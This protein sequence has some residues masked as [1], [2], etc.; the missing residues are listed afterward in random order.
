MNGWNL[1]TFPM[2]HVK[3][4]WKNTNKNNNT[5]TKGEKVETDK[6]KRRRKRRKKK[7]EK[8]IAW[9]VPRVH[10]FFNWVTTNFPR[11]VSSSASAASPP[12]VLHP[13]TRLGQIG[14]FFFIFF[15]FFFLIQLYCKNW[16]LF[17]VWIIWDVFWEWSKVRSACSSQ[18]LC[19][20]LFCFSVFFFFFFFFKVQIQREPWETVWSRFSEPCGWTAVRTASCFFGIDRFLSL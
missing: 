3:G 14:L 7:K 9:W 11:L 10:G 12:F 6:R 15:F 13:T 1:S 2:Y 19:F 20:F 17:C 5:K 8:K 16:I 18:Q 4:L